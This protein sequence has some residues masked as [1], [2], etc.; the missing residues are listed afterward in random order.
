MNAMNS[1]RVFWA[2][3]L[4]AAAT[5]VSAAPVERVAAA[6]LPQS[7]A[8]ISGPAAVAPTAPLPIISAVAPS[9]SVA[10]AFAAAS[11]LA[12]PAAM[13]APA[14]EPANAPE[15]SAAA[16][17]S[18]EGEAAPVA[19]AAAAPAA[20]APE[21]VA[22]TM[23]NGKIVRVLRRTVEE[24]SSLREEGSGPDGVL[25]DFGPSETSWGFPA[26]RLTRARADWAQFSHDGRLTGVGTRGPESLV[27]GAARTVLIL[28]AGRA[29]ELGLRRGAA[30][31]QLG[32]G[33]SVDEVYDVLRS[34]EWA[35]AEAAEA[36]KENGAAEPRF[37]LDGLIARFDAAVRAGGPEA[38]RA[39]ELRGQVLLAVAKHPRADGHL[40]MLAATRLY[41]DDMPRAL[42]R[43]NKSWPRK[44]RATFDYADTWIHETGHELVARLL[45]V[46]V[47]EKRVVAHGAGFIVTPRPGVARQ[48]AIDAAGGSAEASV[49]LSAAAAGA[50][51][52]QSAHGLWLAAAA[53][54]AAALVAFG[55]TM[56]FGAAAHAA[57]DLR[58]SFGLLGWTRA[59]A[60]VSEV[61]A[62]AGR[63]AAARG[64]GFTVP[65][66]VF[67]R[68]AWRRTLA[69]VFAR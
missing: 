47:E 26:A 18:P 19:A 8:P 30:V 4:G 14:A 68:A 17:A 56:A 10:P 41:L 45:G 69:R 37:F 32:E 33:S 52:A 39:A 9:V 29:R 3:A 58:N 53:L 5:T 55:L 7:A 22:L 2:V 40:R 23:P 36:L 43:L 62:E 46:P 66:R 60:F 15:A 1:V 27:G 50:A 6:E 51:L 11:A 35:P 42:F 48:L 61:L 38:A 64:M 12:A 20:Q 49:G 65:A 21:I 59:Q 44:L 28:G 16:A 31:P 25:L 13:S 67:Y 63:D 54:P 57:F 34:G 24:I